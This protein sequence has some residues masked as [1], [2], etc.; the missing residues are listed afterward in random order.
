MD[1]GFFASL[2]DL[3]FTH[4][5][6]TKL[7][8]VLFVLSLIGLVITYFVFAVAIFNAGEET[9]S[10]GTCTGGGG[11]TGLGLLWVFVIG[12]LFLFFYTLLYRVVCEL[13]VVVFRIFENSRDQ[14]AVLRA[15]NPQAADAAT[16]GPTAPVAPTAPLP[17]VPAPAPRRPEPESVEDISLR[18]DE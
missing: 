14:L 3:S 13:L 15:A 16:A 6:T 8:K 11:G 1:K 18:R 10:Y 9:C 17:P 7:V 5:V 2:F 12:P 4:F